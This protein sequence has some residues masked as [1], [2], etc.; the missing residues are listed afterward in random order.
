MQNRSWVGCLVSGGR[1]WV[2]L[3]FLLFRV[4]REQELPDLDEKAQH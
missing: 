1:A 3:M 2:G 4:E